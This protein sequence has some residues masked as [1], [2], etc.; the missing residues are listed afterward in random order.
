VREQL[1]KSD[2]LLL[3]KMAPIIDNDVNKLN[4]LSERPPEIA[5]P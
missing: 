5:A 4:F 2:D 3:R 1:L